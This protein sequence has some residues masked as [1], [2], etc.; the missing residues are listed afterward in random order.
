MHQNPYHP[1]GIG[2]DIGIGTGNCDLSSPAKLSDFGFG[3]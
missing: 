2:I 3:L 1:F